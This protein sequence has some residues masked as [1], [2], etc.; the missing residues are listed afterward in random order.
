MKKTL[1]VILLTLV[2][3]QIW[4]QNIETEI[5]DK[6][7]KIAEKSWSYV[8]GTDITVTEIMNKK[9]ILTNSNFVE[10]T[11]SLRVDG[12]IRNEI[13]KII[14]DDEDVTKKK[15]NSKDFQQI[16]SKNIIPENRSLFHNHP[17]VTYTLLPD[18]EMLDS[19]NCYVYTYEFYEDQDGTPTKMYGKVYIDGVGIPRYRNIFMDP[20]PKKL[21]DF[22]TD[23]YYSFEPELELW[24]PQTVTISF[25]IKFLLINKF[26]KTTKNYA[27][28][29]EYPIKAVN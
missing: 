17:D 29:W 23:I 9:Q 20:I 11:H 26:I 16:A 2:L 25:H 18:R 27:D 7:T 22:S 13:N 3:A 12:T 28:Y 6:A 15:R 1:A 19:I 24:F 21:K 10:V 4:C 14:I 5:W 8:P